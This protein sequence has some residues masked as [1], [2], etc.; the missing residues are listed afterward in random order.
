MAEN[1][2]H[3]SEERLAKRK[4]TEGDIAH[5]HGERAGQD[6]SE[7][8][9]YLATL[10]RDPGLSR[11]GNSAP[12]A[13]ALRSAQNTHGNRA[14]QRFL[15]AGAPTLEPQAEDDD[16]LA[17]RI[18]TLSGGGSSL[19]RETRA[20]LESGLG[21]DLSGVRIHTG[22]EAD[23]LS[24]AMGAT[25]FTTGQDIFF[26]SG[27]FNPHSADG[28]RL[29]AHEATH[30]LQQA[31]G[32]VAGTPSAGGVSI[33]DPSDAF[34]QA[35]E[36]AADAVASGSSAGEGAQSDTPL[37]R[38]IEEEPYI[39]R[40][41]SSTPMSVQRD[42]DEDARRARFNFLPP[43]LELP[44]G[45]LTG[46]LTPGGAEL[47]YQRGGFRAGGEYS[48]GGPL[49]LNMGYGA[50]LQPWMMDVEPSLAAGA[51]ALNNLRGPGVFGALGGMAG[52][53]GDIA[54]SGGPAAN[55]GVGLQ[56]TI[57]PEE[58]RIMAGLRLNF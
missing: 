10:L 39:Q 6:V 19:D 5:A 51:G 23:K 50:P 43:S 3:D 29:I 7:G 18:E 24:R 53:L 32:P 56:A 22:D 37:Q 36:R 48:W 13:Q 49:G 41:T 40:S 45:P 11:R 46:T 55:W 9:D 31:T 58:Q 20:R 14:V 8:L 27:L 57:G 16:F 26:R 30:T 34:E 52:T 42:P 15:S 1:N 17:K 4:G 35:A 54:D 33:S 21:A 44:M 47:G 2:T 12:R 25:A 38:K 28:L